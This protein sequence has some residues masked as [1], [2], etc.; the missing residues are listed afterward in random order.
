MRNNTLTNSQ[1]HG[2]S[3]LGDA[4]RTTVDRNTIAGRGSTPIHVRRAVALPTGR[5]LND[6]SGWSVSRSF[7]DHLKTLLQPLNAMWL[8]VALLVL[9]TAVRGR[10]RPRGFTHPYATRHP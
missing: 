6:T 8:L 10:R 4:S 9:V 7:V 3:I 1:V 5:T 2:I